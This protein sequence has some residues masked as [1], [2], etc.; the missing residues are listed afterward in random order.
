MARIDRLQ[1][2][3]AAMQSDITVNFGAESTS[4]VGKR[5]PARKCER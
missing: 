3:V 5:T 4:S 2:T 1:D